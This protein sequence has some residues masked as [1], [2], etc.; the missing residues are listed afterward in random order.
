M[1]VSVS[2]TG[3]CQCGCGE[4]TSIA[5]KSDRRKGH[6]AG[7]RH[8]FKRGHNRRAARIAR[9]DPFKV[10]SAGCWIV[11]LCINAKGYGWMRDYGTG[12]LDYAHRVFFR[13]HRGAIP[14]GMELDHLCSVRACV[15]PAHLEPV[16]H[17]E[18]L[19]RARA[20][21]RVRA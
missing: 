13:Q 16:T 9:G 18:N 20:A 19:R 11:Q 3:L 7:Q 2:S 6:I 14:E 8:F 5:T 10:D 1:R 15:N 4:P 21:Q 12:K 17:A